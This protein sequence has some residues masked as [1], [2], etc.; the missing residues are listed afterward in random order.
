MNKKFYVT[1][2]GRVYWTKKSAY[3][4]KH[5]F[6]ERYFCSICASITTDGCDCKH[7]RTRR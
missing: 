6:V 3:A 5:N 4:C 1:N 2:N 7:K